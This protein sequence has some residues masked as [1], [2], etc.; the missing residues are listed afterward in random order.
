MKFEEA[1]P[2]KRFFTLEYWTDDGWFVGRLKEIPSVM[3]Q[4]ESLEELKENIVDAYRMMIAAEA[5]PV[6]ADAKTLELGVDL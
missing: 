5:Q 3:S 2:M 6:H 1:N 4:G